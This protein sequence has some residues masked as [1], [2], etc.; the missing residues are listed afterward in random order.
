MLSA[1]PR[2]A[3]PRIDNELLSMIEASQE[4]KL[5]IMDLQS[6]IDDK[7]LPAIKVGTDWRIL[8]TTIERFFPVHQV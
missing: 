5:D 7:S 1:K 2:K 3:S 6:M 4:Y 8:R